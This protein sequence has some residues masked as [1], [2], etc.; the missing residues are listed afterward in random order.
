[1]TRYS[2]VTDEINEVM[3]IPF[4]EGRC[5]T[6]PDIAPTTFANCI[7]VLGFLLTV[8]WGIDHRIHL[9]IWKHDISDAENRN[10]R[11]ILLSS[12]ALQ[13]AIVFLYWFPIV[14]SPFV[15]ALWML[16]LTYELID[17]FVW[18]ATRCELV[19]TMCHGTML[20]ITN[21]GTFLVFVWGAFFHF[22]GLIDLH[23]TYFILI[24]L[25]VAIQTSIGIHVMINFNPENRNCHPPMETTSC[26]SSP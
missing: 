10:H 13:G 9:R 20:V 22:H 25:I 7:L 23:P 21:C 16:R 24:T 12:W 14:A 3:V 4:S 18:H 15:F 17:E 19:E 1:M 2:F 26:T 11:M 6:L 5:M 8:I